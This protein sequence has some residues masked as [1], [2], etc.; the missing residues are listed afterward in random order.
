[1]MMTIGHEG[2][3]YHLGGLD[4]SLGSIYRAMSETTPT[5]PQIG[6]LIDVVNGWLDAQLVS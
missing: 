6:K 4:M 2:R 3:S 5:L 1:M